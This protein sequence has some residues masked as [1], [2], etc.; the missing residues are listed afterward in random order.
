MDEGLAN[1]GGFED[2]RTLRIS[3]T[4]ISSAGLKHLAGLAS[5]RKLD[6]RGSA[7][8]DE[9]INKLQRALPNCK[10]DWNETK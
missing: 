4:Q 9:G 2:L 6:L 10:I 5:L 3:N 1:L 7:V 8:A